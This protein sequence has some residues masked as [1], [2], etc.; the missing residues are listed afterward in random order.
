M[1][2]DMAVIVSDPAV[3]NTPKKT[4]QS[5]EFQKNHIVLQRTAM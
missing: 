4:I 3:C 2:P 1:V 5:G